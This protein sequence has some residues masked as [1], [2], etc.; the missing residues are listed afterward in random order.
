MFFLNSATEI[1]FRSGVTP[2]EVV[3]RGGDATESWHSETHVRVLQVID[4]NSG[5]IV[6]THADASWTTD[7]GQVECPV[8]VTMDEDGFIYVLDGL[9]RCVQLFDSDLRHV[10][11][12]LDAQHGLKEPRRMCVNGQSGRMYVAEGAGSVLVYDII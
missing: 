2:P 4:A 5:L 8:H 10:R 12:L 6:M 9:N 11:D 3:T 7:G 1:N